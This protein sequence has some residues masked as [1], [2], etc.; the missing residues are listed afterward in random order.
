MAQARVRLAG[1]T[2]EQAAAEDA[3]QAQLEAD[4][5]ALDDAA[6]AA[7]DPE[8]AAPEGDAA[9]AQ[10]EEKTAPVESPLEIKAP[11]FGEH[12]GVD[13][14]TCMVP[15][16]IRLVLGNDASHS[17]IAPGMQKLPRAVAEH[18]WCKANGVSIAP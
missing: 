2:D 11:R 3:V 6:A 14:V 13:E 15:K 5:K 4:Q 8:A 18:W 12:D 17:G 1:Q 7:P 10:P 16:A 9:P